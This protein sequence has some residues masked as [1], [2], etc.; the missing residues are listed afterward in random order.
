MGCAWVAMGC[1]WVAAFCCAL[2]PVATLPLEIARNY[3]NPVLGI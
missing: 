2:Q 1:A 3:G